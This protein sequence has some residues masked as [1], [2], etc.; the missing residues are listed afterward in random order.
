MEQTN[1]AP[2][3]PTGVAR[4]GWPPAIDHGVRVKPLLPFAAMLLVRAM[5]RL[6]QSR[7]GGPQTFLMVTALGL[8]ALFAC[9]SP[10][11]D[12]C[13]VK[14]CR[15]EAEFVIRRPYSSFSLGL[16]PQNLPTAYPIG[17]GAYDAMTECPPIRPI[18]QAF[19][20]NSDP[21]PLV[22]FIGLFWVCKF[23]WR[24]YLGEDAHCLP[25]C[26]TGG[27]PACYIMALARACKITKEIRPESNAR[28]HGSQPRWLPLKLLPA[29]YLCCDLIPT[30][31][32]YV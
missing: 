22:P 10:C 6:K 24:L 32:A 21:D 5:L 3:D 25:R 14:P 11:H 26:D 1:L 17:T 29:F 16:Q 19:R 28:R 8:R 18:G 23:G 2:A 12:L 20:S 9:P 13:Q 31:G 4:C 7:A 30:E 15:R 27:H